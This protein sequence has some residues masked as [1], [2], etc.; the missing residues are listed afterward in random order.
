MSQS[1]GEGFVPPAQVAPERLVQRES[2]A[3]PQMLQTDPDCLVG[4]P[5]VMR[6]QGNG[7]ICI[8]NKE[9]DRG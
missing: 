4:V 7:Y 5:S 8:T 1:F 6:P 2:G 3:Y 9:E